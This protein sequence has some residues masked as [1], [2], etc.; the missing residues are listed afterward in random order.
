MGARGF[1]HASP[2][3]RRLATGDAEQTELLE[4]VQRQ[5]ERLARHSC[6]CRG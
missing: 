6:D 5:R 2:L 4:P 1:R 3:D